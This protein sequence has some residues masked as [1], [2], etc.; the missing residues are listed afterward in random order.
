MLVKYENI[1]FK[2]DKRFVKL[3]AGLIMKI[4]LVNTS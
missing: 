4:K 2:E 3:E 1:C